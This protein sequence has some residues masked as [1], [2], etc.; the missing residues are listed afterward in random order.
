MSQMTDDEI[1][2]ALGL[3]AEQLQTFK[4]AYGHAWRELAIPLISMNRAARELDELMTKRPSALHG[5]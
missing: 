1:E 5:R 2:N 4:Q 3:T